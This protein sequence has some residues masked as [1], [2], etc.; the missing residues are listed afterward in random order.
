MYTK[1]CP[2]CTRNSY[3]SCEIHHWSC[4]TCSEDLTIKK[5][6]IPTNIIYQPKILKSKKITLTV[7]N[8]KFDKVI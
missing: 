5:A 2:I 7:T 1:T 8:Y 4:P 6:F 3:S